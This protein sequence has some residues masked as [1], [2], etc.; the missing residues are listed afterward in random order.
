MLA[1]DEV[2]PPEK[3]RTDHNLEGFDSGELVLDDWLRR[4]AIRNE[5]TGASRTYVIC[6][7]GLV[8]GY[9]ALAVGTVEAAKAI[10]SS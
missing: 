10:T 7:K 8:V 5:N 1:D 2:T 3:I 6:N 9:Y 4:R